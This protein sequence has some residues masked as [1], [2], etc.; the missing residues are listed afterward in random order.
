MTAKSQNAIL[1]A[2]ELQERIDYDLVTPHAGKRDYDGKDNIQTAIEDLSRKHNIS[3][4]YIRQGRQMLKYNTESAA[5]VL[6]GRIS[7]NASKTMPRSEIQE[8]LGLGDLK[9]A[10]EVTNDAIEKRNDLIR[11][12]V[13]TEIDVEVITILIELEV[14]EVEKIINCSLD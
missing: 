10:A 2:L 1:A 7:L 3:E 8:S 13:C 9:H 11:K 14:E 4:A 5:A 6:S 12:V